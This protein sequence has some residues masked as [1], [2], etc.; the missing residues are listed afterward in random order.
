MVKVTQKDPS[1][2]FEAS[3]QEL[4]QCEECVF[5]YVEKEQAEKCELWCKEHHSCN[6][7]I[8]VHAEENKK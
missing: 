6:L 3:N 7:E 8:T 1:T 4:Y 5:H 2:A